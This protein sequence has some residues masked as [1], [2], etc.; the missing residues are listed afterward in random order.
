MVRFIEKRQ[1]HFVFTR[2]SAH[3]LLYLPMTFILWTTLL[4]T[5]W[6]CWLFLLTGQKR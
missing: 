4:S 6:I 2:N 5:K 3:R 1:I